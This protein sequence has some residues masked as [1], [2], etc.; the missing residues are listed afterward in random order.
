MRQWRQAPKKRLICAILTCPVTA[1]SGPT[2]NKAFSFVRLHCLIRLEEIFQSIFA[3][4]W[5]AEEVVYS[6]IEQCGVVI[7]NHVCCIRE[8]AEFAARQ[9]VIDLQRVLV[10]Y[11]IVV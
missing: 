11:H 10:A 8:D 7:R 3:D 1:L 6:R 2:V 5:R 9:M 4:E